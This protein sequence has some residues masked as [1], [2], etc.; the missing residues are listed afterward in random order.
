MTKRLRAADKRSITDRI[1]DDQRFNKEDVCV[2]SAI[3]YI[4]RELGCDHPTAAEIAYVSRCSAAAVK[5]SIEVA[6]MYGVL[7]AE[8]EQPSRKGGGKGS[9]HGYY[10][11]TLHPDRF[12]ISMDYQTFMEQ[13]PASTTKPKKQFP[14]Q[15]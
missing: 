9:N 7:T 13:N 14:L 11:Y 15:T 1:L 6:K 10:H 2:L 8:Y 3:D 4:N 12:I 5:K